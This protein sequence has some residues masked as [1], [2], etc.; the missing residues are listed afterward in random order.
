LLEW[1][2]FEIEIEGYNP[3]IIII[4]NNSLEKNVLLDC[5]KITFFGSRKWKNRFK[6]II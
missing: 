3:L 2:K 6:N 5:R 1:P 4:E